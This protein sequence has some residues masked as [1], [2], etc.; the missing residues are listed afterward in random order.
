MAKVSAP[1]TASPLVRTGQ[2]LVVASR[3]AVGLVPVKAGS[4]PAFEGAGDVAG[5]LDGEGLGI[6]GGVEG[7]DDGGC[8]EVDGVG[9]AD[10]GDEAEGGVADDEVAVAFDEDAGGGVE[11]ERGAGEDELVAG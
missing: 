7:A 11:G 1:V 4:V 8:G 9:G 5:L 10:D 2:V 6:V 3:K